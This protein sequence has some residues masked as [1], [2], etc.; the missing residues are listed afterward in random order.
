MAEQ[1][2]Y[3]YTQAALGEADRAL[4]DFAAKLTLKPGAMA[5]ADFDGLRQPGFTEE[6]ITLAVQVIGYFNYINRVAEGLGVDPESWM[7]PGP[8]EWRR[9]K[10]KFSE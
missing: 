2:I 9:R 7:K 3:D 8:A 6:Q 1:L 4:C 10:G 5:Q